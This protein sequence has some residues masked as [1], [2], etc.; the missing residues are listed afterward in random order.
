MSTSIQSAGIKN[1]IKYFQRQRDCPIHRDKG[2]YRSSHR[3][4]HFNRA[5][6]ILKKRLDI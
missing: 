4:K 2:K 6:F 3:G 5:S 1:D